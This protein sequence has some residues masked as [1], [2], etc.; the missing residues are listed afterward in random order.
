MGADLLLAVI[1]LRETKAQC[2]K[3]INKL[4]WDNLDTMYRK[5]ENAGICIHDDEIRGDDRK[6]VKWMKERLEEAV[7]S[8]Y[9]QQF[10]RDVSSVVVDGAIKF[11][12]TGGTSWGDDPSADWDE[13]NLFNELL[14]YPYWAKPKSKERKEWEKIGKRK[15]KKD[16]KCRH[17]HEK[18]NHHT[19]GGMSNGDY[20]TCGVCG[21]ITQV[22]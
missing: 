16:K 12:I 21:E 14:G 7:N 8:C 1:E 18:W 4:D 6:V 11:L 19:D 5:F 20:Y 10:G 17:P 13:F 2:L 9:A 22:G 3:R 15:P